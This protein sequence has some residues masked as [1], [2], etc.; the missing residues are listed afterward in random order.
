[1]PT[2]SS[3]YQSLIAIDINNYLVKKY[4]HNPNSELKEYLSLPT[5][6]IEEVL[7]KELGKDELENVNFEEENMDDEDQ[8]AQAIKIRI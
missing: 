1:L 6:E 4:L 7:M 5:E 2:C 3:P 8:Q